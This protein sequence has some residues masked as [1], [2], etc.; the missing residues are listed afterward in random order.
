MTFS[1]LEDIYEPHSVRLNAENVSLWRKF[2][3]R[4]IQ[5]LL[6]TVLPMKKHSQY[7][8]KLTNTIVEILGRSNISDV[9]KKLQLETIALITGTSDETRTA[10]KSALIMMHRTGNMLDDVNVLSPDNPDGFKNN[11][12]KSLII[13]LQD[14]ISLIGEESVYLNRLPIVK[15]WYDQQFFSYEDT[16]YYIGNYLDIMLSMA[17]LGLFRCL[18]QA[19]VYL[20][21]TA[22]TYYNAIFDIDLLGVSIEYE[23]TSSVYEEETGGAMLELYNVQK[24]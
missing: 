4:S 9:A 7:F 18:K 1:E 13:V 5:R 16:S 12:A 8:Q 22:I 19:G 20:K 21:S 11:N 23:Y 10:F 15:E 3:R 24:E 2:S 6:R 14:R 17:K